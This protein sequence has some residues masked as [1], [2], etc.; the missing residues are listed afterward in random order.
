MPRRIFK[1]SG[2]GGGGKLP[3]L[4]KTAVSTRSGGKRENWSFP[5]TSSDLDRM[6][7]R[8]NNEINMFYL[9]K[10]WL[11]PIVGHYAFKCFIRGSKYIF[12]GNDCVRARGN[13]T[14]VEEF[15]FVPALFRVGVNSPMLDRA[16][17]VQA[18]GT[19]SMFTFACYLQSLHLRGGDP[20]RL[21][22]WVMEC[23]EY[24]CYRIC[25]D[26]LADNV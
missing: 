13:S 5:P 10:S 8:M 7:S 2:G 17:P 16:L 26:Y 4:I 21:V 6:N 18:H 24:D 9:G 3:P 11:V 1:S 12:N 14:H 19:C 23:T 15:T 22:N 20:F 25:V